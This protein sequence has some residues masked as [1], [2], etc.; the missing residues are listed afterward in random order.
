[1]C[2][3]PWA[4]IREREFLRASMIVALFAV[5]LLPAFSRWGLKWFQIGG[6][7]LV[8][9]VIVAIAEQRLRARK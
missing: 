7:L 8:P 9:I 3:M 1:M 5:A 4:L 6:A 2:V